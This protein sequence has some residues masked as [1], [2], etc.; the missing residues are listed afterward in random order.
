VQSKSHIRISFSE[1]KKKNPNAPTLL[2]KA[3]FVT[4]PPLSELEYATDL[5]LSAVANYQMNSEFGS[6]RFLK[7]VDL[8]GLCLD[9]IVDFN[10]DSIEFYPEGGDHDTPPL[11][12]EINVPCI[13]TFNNFGDGDI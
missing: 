5:Q 9:L 1:K 10:Q 3:S 11:G 7:P 13:V 2:K 6:I 4:V 12:K 8:R